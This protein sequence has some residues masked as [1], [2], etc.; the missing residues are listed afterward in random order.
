MLTPQQ[1]EEA[2]KANGITPVNQAP[3]VNHAG[4]LQ[5]AWAAADA[6][7]KTDP[8][9]IERM[10]KN[11]QDSADI[12]GGSLSEG[13]QSMMG[14]FKGMVEK[15]KTADSP[16][17]ILNALVFAG[18]T[19]GNIAKATG[20]SILATAK[21][22]LS[23]ISQMKNQASPEGKTLG[24]T[25][26]E[27][28]QQKAQ[29]LIG[30][31]AKSHPEVVDYVAKQAEAHPDVARGISD[32]MYAYTLK[33]L[34]DSTFLGDELHPSADLQGI[35]Q[36]LKSDVQD[37]VSGTKK[38]AD[39]AAAKVSKSALD[40]TVQAVN[41]DLTGKKLAGAY[42]DVVK[43]TRTA[44]SRGLFTE[45]KLSP[46]QQA[47]NIATR[48]QQDVGDAETSV[49]KITLT[50]KPVQDLTKL[51]DGMQTTE[52]QI[53]TLLD[54][55]PSLVYNADKPSL[56]DALNAIKDKSPREFGSIK[57][58]KAVYDDVINYAKETVDQADDTVKGIREARAT[59]D[60]AAKKQFPSAYKDGFIDT[61]TPAG[62]AI[63]AARDT[64][65][66]HLYN[67]APEGSLIQ[68][69]IQREADLFRAAQN[70]A[71]KAAKLHGTNII[72]SALDA[73]R[74]HP[75]L[76]AIGVYEMAKHSVAPILPG[77]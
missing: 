56:V 32:V 34:K 11:V 14:D 74:Q 37:L 39:A 6:K 41:P 17:K 13:A 26:S 75:Y 47:I 31:L 50:G 29:K 9:Y 23:P 4:G 1:I 51:A 22:I 53:N 33:G 68:Q 58:S 25:F 71:P 2:R 3:V 35:A 62:I 15:N 43:G 16:T 28:I 69:L 76:S 72:G 66:E 21:T 63:K 70:I 49:P 61:K 8:S 20:T 40:K 10:Q 45:Q 60:A 48:L 7:Q 65:N 59:F 42:E 54:G 55:D 57:E 46:G 5:D 27:P 38:T 44:T 18:H 12:V 67:T 36:G 64:I 24:Q 77:I 30:A 73:L 19:A 52:K